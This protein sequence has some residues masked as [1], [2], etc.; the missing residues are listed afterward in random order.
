VWVFQVNVDGLAPIL[1]ARPAAT[2][3]PRK[4]DGVIQRSERPARRWG[5]LRLA[6]DL[7]ADAPAGLEVA[8]ATAAPVTM[9]AIGSSRQCRPTTFRQSSLHVQARSR[10][11]TS[12]I[13]R[14]PRAGYVAAL[15][16]LFSRW[17]VM[18][19]DECRHDGASRDGC[20]VDGRLTAGKAGCV[21][22]HCDQASQCTSEHFQRPM[23][24]MALST[25]MSGTMRRRRA[26][27]RRSR[28]NGWPTDLQ[29]H[30]RSTSRCVRLHR[31]IR[32]HSPIGYSAQL[33]S[34]AKVALA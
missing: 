13:S 9:A 25:A 4:S 8:A 1:S 21:V 34:S 5:G 15:I 3:R 7:A 29:H 24:D 30:R 28:P 16:D 31:R 26:S 33:N 20:G 18:G 27:S 17:V 6:P 22:D 12:P 2:G 14:R 23:A 32:R 19:G 11:P 10:S